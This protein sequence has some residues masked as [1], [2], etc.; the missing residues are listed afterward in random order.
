MDL[1]SLGRRSKVDGVV[2]SGW[3]SWLVMGAEDQARRTLECPMY[4]R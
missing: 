3:A 1:E 2:F 4:I